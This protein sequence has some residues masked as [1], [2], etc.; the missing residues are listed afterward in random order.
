MAKTVEAL[1]ELAESQL[2]YDRYQDPL[3]GTVYG[4]WYA[5][6]TNSPWFGTTGVPFC[7]MFASWCLYKLGIPCIGTPTASCTSGLLTA[8]RSAGKL[9]RVENGARGDLILFNWN[10]AG[11]YASE[12][13][14]VGIIT[15]NSGATIQTIEGN[16]DGGKVL[17]RTR[18]PSEVVGCIRPAF[19][20]EQ[21]MAFKDVYKSTPHYQDIVWMKEKGI[22]KGYPDGTYRPDAALTRGDAAAFL[23]RLYNVIEGK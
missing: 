3:P 12:A 9:L 5:D 1:I 19:E 23:H 2:G 21:P 8:A 17:R 22:A 10:K 7:A 4:R 13:D 11:Y 6:L 20:E 14:H 16:V 18:Y 15:S